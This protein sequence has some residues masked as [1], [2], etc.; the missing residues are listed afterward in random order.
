MASKPSNYNSLVVV[1]RYAALVAL[2]VWL[3]ALQ[4]VLVGSATAYN[5]TIAYA[6]GPVLVICLLAL[7]FVG[8]PPRAFFIRVGIVLLM[9]LVTLLD[10]WL[11]T[12]Q[13]PTI[14]NMAL[15]LVLLAWYAHE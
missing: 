13:L 10:R 5:T 12:G 9:L 6:C 1:V 11:I 8:P 14:V 2:V 3:G 15:G 7:K 4:S